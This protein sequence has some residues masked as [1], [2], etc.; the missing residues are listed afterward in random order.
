MMVS[1]RQNFIVPAVFALLGVVLIGAPAN[2][3]QQTSSAAVPGFC[4]SAR[5]AIE[6]RD[7]RADATEVALSPDGGRLSSAQPRR[8]HGED[9]ALQASAGSRRGLAH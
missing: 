8:K 5:H 4:A 1:A 9:E 7:A 3:D 6:Q 2:R